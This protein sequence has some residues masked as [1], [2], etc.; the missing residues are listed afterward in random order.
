MGHDETGPN[1]EMPQVAT[2][3]NSKAFRHRAPSNLGQVSRGLVDMGETSVR[4]VALKTAS[5][6]LL[7]VQNTGSSPRMEKHSASFGLNL[8]IIRQLEK[9][10]NVFGDDHTYDL[11]HPEG[12]ASLARAAL[13]RLGEGWT[14]SAT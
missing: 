3:C 11:F 7:C 10:Q 2:S 6:S 13:K 9:T 14:V 8:I 5:S 12:S 1:H 4:W